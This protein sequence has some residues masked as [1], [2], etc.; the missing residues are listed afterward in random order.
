MKQGV[1]TVAL[2]V[3][4]LSVPRVSAWGASGAAVGGVVRDAQ[5]TPQMGALVELLA[6]D[7]TVIARAFTDDHGRYLLSSVLPGR[8]RLRA[9]AAFL[10]PATREDLRLGAGARAIA[11]LTMSALF[12]AGSWLPAQK[13]RAGEPSDDWQWMLRSTANRPLLRLAGEDKS[14]NSQITSSSAEHG[15]APA[16]D[17]EVVLMVGDG[18]FGQGGTRQVV[19]VDHAGVDGGVSVLRASV[20]QDT[21]GLAGP[22]FMVAAGMERQSPFG[23][24]TRLLASA[25]ASPELQTTNGVGLQVFQVAVVHKLVMGDA[26][27]IDAGT[28][29]TAERLAGTRF[30]S[31]PYIR[32]A[33]RLA[34]ETAVEYRMATDRNLQCSEDLDGAAVHEEGLSDAQGRPILR[35]GVHQELALT[36]TRR[37]RTVRLAI[38]RDALPVEAVQGGGLAGG[39]LQPELPALVDPTTG[40]FRIAAQGMTTPGVR[41]AWSQELSDM[42]LASAAAEVGQALQ[43]NG[44]SLRPAELASALRPKAAVAASAALQMRARRTGTIVSAHYRWQPYR[45]LTQVNEFDTS[46]M[47]AYL[48]ISMKQRLWSGRRLRGVNAVV[49]ATNLLAEGYEPLLGADGHT[50]FLA[51]VPR[52]VSGGLAFTF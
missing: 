34:P 25:T 23:G 14:A 5:G 18:S 36:D 39:I 6:G 1:R 48:G 17:G 31:A 4:L 26:F 9:S 41:V 10:Q 51:Q 30:N 7:A 37:N 40:T 44:P 47:D 22:S 46:E 45:S 35:R 20:R 49:E 11:N 13:R 52:G 28:L 42:F 43:A 50:L 19:S 33:F 2:L 24:G 27:V 8:Y 38:Y 21:P 15:R 3:L 16:S 29:S 12:E 32:V